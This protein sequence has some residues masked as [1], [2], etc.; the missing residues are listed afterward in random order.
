[1]GCGGP[2]MAPAL[3]SSLLW[4]AQTQPSKQTLADGN[5][6][7]WLAAFQ[8][9]M[10]CLLRT[11]RRRELQDAHQRVRMATVEEERLDLCL[12]NLPQ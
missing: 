2:V 1:M 6:Q 9:R 4:N 12:E 11:G 5:H 8:Q 7:Q 3:E 10:S